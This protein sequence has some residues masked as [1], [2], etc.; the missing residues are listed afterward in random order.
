[1]RP[2]C[3]PPSKRLSVLWAT[4]APLNF[5]EME[6]SGPAVNDSDYYP[7]YPASSYPQIRI[8]QH[9]LTSSSGGNVLAHAYYSWDQ[10][11]GLS[12]DI[13]FDNKDT[14]SDGPFSGYDFLE[15]ATHEIGHALSIMHEESGPTAIMNPYYGSR[16]SGLG[17][18]FLFADDIAAIQGMYGAGVGSVTSLGN[19][20]PQLDPIADQSVSHSVDSFTVAV[21]A[22]DYEGDPLTYTAAIV[23]Q[24]EV[25]LGTV[26]MTGTTLTIDPA[27]GY[28]G[29]YQIVITVSDGEKTDS[30]TFNVS[31]TNAAPI[32]TISDQTMSPLD[33][34]LVMTLSGS[35]ADNDPITYV[36]GILLSPE[37]EAYGYDITY[38][39]YTNQGDIDNNYW[40]NLFGQNEK[41]IRG[42]ADSY[43][44]LADG[45]FYEFNGSM[46]ASTFLGTLDSSYYADPFKLYN[47]IPTVDPVIGVSITGNQLTLD[48]PGGFS[49]TF[50]VA[51][52]A[53]DGITAT[54]TIFTVTV[55]N[56]SPTLTAISDQTLAR[57]TDS[58]D[59]ALSA[60]DGDGDPMTYT[61]SIVPQSSVTI[62][63][64]SVTG[65][66]LTISPDGN[67]AGTFQVTVT[68]TDGYLSDT[69]TFTV[70]V[71]N[72]VPTFI[73][74]TDQT[75]LNSD[76]SLV[77]TLN[78]SDADGDALNFSANAYATV[79]DPAWD[80]KQQYGL[81]ATQ[82]DINAGGYYN[83]FG[84]GEKHI[85]GAAD[86]YF[87]LTNGDFYKLNGSIADSV[88]LQ[89][90]DPAYFNDLSILYD[91]QAPVGPI[92]TAS[93]TGNQLTL[94]PPVDFT[95][96]ITVDVTVTDGAATVTQTFVVTVSAGM[97]VVEST[98][99]TVSESSTTTSLSDSTTS[100]SSSSDSTSTSSTTTTDG[101][102]VSSDGTLSSGM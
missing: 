85:R 101:T 91:A 83:L 6:D 14:W 80:L 99:P 65:S 28:M 92:I 53:V 90:V 86:S 69:Q 26:S 9:D 21:S 10:S 88:F 2:T 52:T 82:A 102:S 30:Q 66:T 68:A 79:S 67:F 96:T 5:V 72:E 77:V 87:M 70:T 73:D 17:T 4:Y 33:D 7:S 98:A 57:T 71:T 49:G 32:L 41:H 81:Y 29:T 36:A 1:M 24:S 18:G 37:A 93:I 13:H 56:Q 60:T 64:V 12:G 3:V 100:E 97:T 55:V 16:F 19:N 74:I 43:Y 48:P 78:A 8:G 62:G 63:T 38:G 47:A 95:G 76:G 50:R 75:M 84:L 42:S 22:T 59:V 23:P 51:A 11:Y 25:D 31:V 34:T 40:Q 61:A 46:A 44:L 35:D 94:T 58:I 54:T 15:V 20:T 89:T 27:V 45:S 39:L